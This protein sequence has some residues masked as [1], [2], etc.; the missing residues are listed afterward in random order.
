MKIFQHHTKHFLRVGLAAAL[1]GTV[2]LAS[3]APIYN[4]ITPLGTLGGR[5]NTVVSDFNDAGQ[6]VGYFQTED[7]RGNTV[8]HAFLYSAGVMTDLGTLGGKNSYA[9]AINNAGQVVGNAAL[10]PVA[11]SFS[12]IPKAFLYGNNVMSNLGIPGDSSYAFDINDNGLV[13]GYSNTRNLRHAFLYSNGITTDLGTLG[14][15]ESEANGINNAGTVIGESNTSTNLRHAFMY[16]D[17][18]MTDLGTL[19]GTLSTARDINNAGQVVGYSTISS[20]GPARAYLYSGGKM[21]DLGTLAAVND[22]DRNTYESFAYGI[23]DAGQVVGQAQNSWFFSSPFLYSGGVMKNLNDLIDP[24]S[25]FIISQAFDINAS[26]DILASGCLR[27]GTKCQSL[28]LESIAAPPNDVP[29][30]E[31]LALVSLGLAGL[32]LGSRKRKHAVA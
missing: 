29:E 21:T 12:Q 22:P 14:G 6:M 9:D 25:D 17:G 27:N 19:G 5:L 4:S 30:P 15:L 7:S 18:K 32:A 16:S 26:G 28:L 23:N 3:A 8:N 20:R 24:A 10:E 11:P 2:A 1:L 13:V 31:T